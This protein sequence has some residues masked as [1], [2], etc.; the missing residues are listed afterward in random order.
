MSP[1]IE[2]P[3]ILRAANLIKEFRPDFRCRFLGAVATVA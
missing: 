2:I 3:I 1:D